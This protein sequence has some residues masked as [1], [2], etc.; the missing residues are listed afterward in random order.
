MTWFYIEAAKESEP[1]LK[2][3]WIHAD[4][5]EGSITMV[6]APG[7]V[8]LDRL[9]KD[10]QTLVPAYLGEPYLNE[11]R[12][13]NPELKSIW[14]SFDALDPR[15]GTSV[16][17]GRRQVRAILAGFRKTVTEFMGLPA[18]QHASRRRSRKA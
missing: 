2:N 11:T 13:Y 12:G 9:P 8:H 15:S 5:W 4:K 17:Y 6:A 10:R 16:A 3:H 18:E 7:T 1:L 14:Y